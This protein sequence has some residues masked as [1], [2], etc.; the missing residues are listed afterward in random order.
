MPIGGAVL[1]EKD[2]AHIDRAAAMAVEG[3]LVELVKDGAR[4]CKVTLAYAP[5]CDEPL[6]AGVELTDFVGPA[7]PEG[8][9]SIQGYPTAQRH[10]RRIQVW[11]ITD[12]YSGIVSPKVV[13]FSQN[14]L[15]R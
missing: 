4:G 15:G 11:E 6:E 14:G 9:R 7:W 12:C 1:C 8:S 3:A 2:F 13:G 10:Q 5:N